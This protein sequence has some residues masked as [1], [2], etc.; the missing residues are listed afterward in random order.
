VTVASSYVHVVELPDVDAH[1]WLV[2]WTATDVEKFPTA[3]S[4]LNAIKA[5]D[6]R[7]IEVDG[8]DVA[9]TQIVWEPR[10]TVGRLVVQTITSAKS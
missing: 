10:S 8:Y 3:V 4:A 7:R 9:T 6:A 2:A 5:R 1:G